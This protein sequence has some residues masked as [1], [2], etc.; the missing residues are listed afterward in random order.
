M[1]QKFLSC[2]RRKLWSPSFQE[3]TPSVIE[4]ARKLGLKIV[5]WTVNDDHDIDRV[6]NLDVDGIISD[7]PDRVR[8]KMHSR[9]I[10]LSW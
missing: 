2:W 4:Q 1:V 8:T 3:M 7:Y 9:G 6:L 10:K 5:V